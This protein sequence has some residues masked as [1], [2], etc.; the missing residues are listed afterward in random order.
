MSKEVYYPLLRRRANWAK[1]LI[2]EY[3]LNP[4]DTWFCTI[5]YDDEHLPVSF[6]D[7]DLPQV[8]V[9]KRDVQLWF[10]RIR[11]NY[12]ARLGHIRYFIV[13]E[14]GENTLRPHYHAIIFT[15]NKCTTELLNEAILDTWK[16]GYIVDVSRVRGDGALRYVANYILSPTQELRTLCLM[17]R[18]PGLGR[19]YVDRLIS[20]HR[21][22]VK[23]IELCPDDP[24]FQTILAHCLYPT[25]EKR[26]KRLEKRKFFSY[27]PGDKSRGIRSSGLPRYFA[28]KLY[29][30]FERKL[31]FLSYIENECREVSRL[32]PA[33]RQS[34][35]ALFN[36]RERMAEDRYRR[37]LS[38]HGGSALAQLYYREKK[39]QCQDR[40]GCA[41]V[42]VGFCNS[43]HVESWLGVV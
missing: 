1:R 9:S 37:S 12:G 42:G 10:K 28:E 25:F 38:K 20:W 32:S 26:I 27:L 3:R 18:R 43:E 34:R 7:D 22:G 6:D 15:E 11:E 5:T 16:N 29:T 4:G 35:F 30:S 21:H 36:N 2:A 39:L 23:P 41:D 24:E 13:S 31:L 40:S 33:D 17:S 19:R 8:D 14:F